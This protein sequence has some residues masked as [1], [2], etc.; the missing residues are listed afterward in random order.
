VEAKWQTDP[1]GGQPDLDDTIISMVAGFV[2]CQLE[3]RLASREKLTHGG[4]LPHEKAALPHLPCS[5]SIAK[6]KEL[7][8]VVCSGV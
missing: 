2:K 7:E 3:F 8:H 5:C 1:I 6:C 4:S